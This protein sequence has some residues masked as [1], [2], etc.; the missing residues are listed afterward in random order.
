MSERMLQ[1]NTV[2][3]QYV[4]EFFIREMEMPR[5]LFVSITKVKTSKDL[6]YS[7]IYLT[8]I[9]DNKRGTALRLLRGQRGRIHKYLKKHLHMKYIPRVQFNIDGQ[10]AYG[11]QM[12]RLLEDIHNDSDDQQETL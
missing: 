9:P 2:I 3:R 11:Q 1:V 8:V 12:D 6:R 10:E 7:T 4:D 5:D